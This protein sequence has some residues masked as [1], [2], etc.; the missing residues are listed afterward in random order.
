MTGKESEL[1]KWWPELTIRMLALS[2]PGNGLYNRTP[3]SRT[4]KGIEKLFEIAG[5]RDS[6]VGRISGVIV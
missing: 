3:L 4:L 2:R 6:E 5:V 1:N